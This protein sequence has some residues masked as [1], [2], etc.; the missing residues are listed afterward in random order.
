M[1]VDDRFQNIRAG[2]SV[3]LLTIRMQP[4]LSLALP[5][6]LNHVKQ[7]SSMTEL[8]EFLNNR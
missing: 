2:L 1:F 5:A 6:D 8:A 4:K 3:G 7:V